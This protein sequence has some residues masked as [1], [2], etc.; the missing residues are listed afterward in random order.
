MFCINYG[1]LKYKYNLLFTELHLQQ[2]ILI[3]IL[4]NYSLSKIIAHLLPTVIPIKRLLLF[5]RMLHLI[6][7][8]LKI[9]LPH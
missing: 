4:V 1:F 3:C 2:Q 6:L 8:E 5:V 9:Q 7:E